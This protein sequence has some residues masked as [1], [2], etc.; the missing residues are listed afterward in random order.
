MNLSLPDLNLS[1]SLILYKL[2]FRRLL[3][4]ESNIR[5]DSN[6]HPY[7]GPHDMVK[8]H[9]LILQ[10]FFIKKK[11][12]SKLKQKKKKNSEMITHLLE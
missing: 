11:V 8:R 1:L 12:K 7:H 4:H 6:A 2:S 5:C 3:S 9:N 10:F